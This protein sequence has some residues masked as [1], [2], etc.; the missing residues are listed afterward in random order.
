MPVNGRNRFVVSHE[1][2]HDLSRLGN[3][4]VALYRLEHINLSLEGDDRGIHLVEFPLA[5]EFGDD[6]VDE[7]ES[8]LRFAQVSVR[9]LDVSLVAQHFGLYI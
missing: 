9:Q 1:V 4:A 5:A 6:T 8:L 3:L 7:G 2:E